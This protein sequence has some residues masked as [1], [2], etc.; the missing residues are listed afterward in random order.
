MMPYDMESL[1]IARTR[2]PDLQRYAALEF[3]PASRA[4]A[5]A[6]AVAAP[7]ARPERRGG[8]TSALF[9]YLFRR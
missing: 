5:Q 6:A 7:G 4:W 3:A 2:N 1:R 8:W 9:A